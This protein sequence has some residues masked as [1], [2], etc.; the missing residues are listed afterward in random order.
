MDVDGRISWFSPDPRAILPVE[1]FHASKNI[2]RAYER[3]QFDIRIDT[4]FL[5]VLRSCGDRPEGTWI[6]EEMIAAYT[7]LHRLGPAHSVEAWRDGKLAG[8][9]YGVVIGGAFFGE[10][11]F[12]RVRDASKVALFALVERLR[13]GGFTLLDVQWITAHL[14]RFGAVEISQE[15]YR[16]RL[17]AAI[18]LR[19]RFVDPP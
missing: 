4:A 5:E 18:R 3:R 12:Y 7:E 17:A 1:G 8:G 13:R 6:S 9:L 10:S 16:S 2:Q 14:R 19:C 11:M 15:D